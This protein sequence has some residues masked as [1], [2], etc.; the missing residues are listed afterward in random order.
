MHFRK[1]VSSPLAALTDFDACL[2]ADVFRAVYFSR[3]TAFVSLV[4]LSFLQSTETAPSAFVPL[5][6]VQWNTALLIPIF[7]FFLFLQK[8]LPAWEIVPDR[9]EPSSPLTLR[10][11]R[12]TPGCV[13]M[14]SAHGVGYST[15]AASPLKSFIWKA[16]FAEE[17]SDQ[18]PLKQFTGSQSWEGLR[19][20]FEVGLNTEKDFKKK[21]TEIFWR[22]L[23]L[24][25][26]CLFL[27]GN[28]FI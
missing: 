19:T 26:T 20:I 23:S 25:I 7:L 16:Q 17:F 4:V 15:Q 5:G 18:L 3:G 6:K 28:C 1:W 21:K 9:P 8:K 13:K 10:A 22:C 11:V 2:L 24:L 12:P 14:E 27:Q